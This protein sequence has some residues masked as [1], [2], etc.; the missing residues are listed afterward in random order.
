MQPIR[1]FMLEATNKEQRSLRRFTYSDRSPCPNSEWGHDASVPI[2]TGP[3][4]ERASDDLWPHED[5]RWPTH[6]TACG[7]EFQD[8]D[9]WM[10]DRWRVYVRVDTGEEMTLDHRTLPP[11]AMYWA[12][13]YSEAAD[14]IFISKYHRERGGGPHLMVNTPGG[15]WDVDIKSSNGDGWERTGEPPDVTATPSILIH[16]NDGSARYHGWLRNGQL[17]EA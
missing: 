7:Y 14:E 10:L 5:P 9:E 16:N 3:Y 2:E 15:I 6:C 8:G 1:C 13:W 11:G 4:E 17:V 12:T